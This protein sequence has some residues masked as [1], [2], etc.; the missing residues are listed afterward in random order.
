MEKIVLKKKPS[1]DDEED[2]DKNVCQ[3]GIEV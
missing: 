1:R 3:R 2:I